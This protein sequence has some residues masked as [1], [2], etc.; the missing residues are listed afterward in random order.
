METV[1][2]LFSGCGGF[3]LGFENAG[4]K[5]V[6]WKNSKTQWVEEPRE[7]FNSLKTQTDINRQQLIKSGT[8]RTYKEDKGFRSIKDDSFPTIP[9][10]AREDGS[11]QPVILQCSIRRL[12]PLECFRLQG[13]PDEIVKRGYEIGISDTQLYKMCGNAVSIPIVYEIA[14]RIKQMEI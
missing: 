9:A 5:I 13:F 4:F 1:F 2:D 14:K 7:Y 11:G 10:R 8:L 3:R 6:Y 12:T